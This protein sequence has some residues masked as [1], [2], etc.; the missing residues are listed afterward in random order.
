MFSNADQF[1][2]LHVRRISPFWIFISE[3]SN[4]ISLCCR[5]FWR[6]FWTFI[7]SFVLTFWKLAD[8]L[9]I[10]DRCVLMYFRNQGFIDIYLCAFWKLADKLTMS[11]RCVLMYFRNQGLLTYIYVHFGN[12]LIN[13][14]CLIDVSLCTSETKDF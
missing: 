4:T 10:Y 6:T 7:I 11:D 5:H 1:H 2:G 13:W 14:Q 8:E 9:T 12:L 3:I